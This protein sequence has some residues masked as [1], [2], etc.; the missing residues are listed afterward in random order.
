[1]VEEKETDK[2][3]VKSLKREKN[4]PVGINVNKKI[5]VSGKDITK[6]VRALLTAH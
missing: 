1:M 6:K 4:V 3:Y 5:W 2:K